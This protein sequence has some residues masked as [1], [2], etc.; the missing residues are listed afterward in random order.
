MVL[1]ALKEK[2]KVKKAKSLFGSLSKYRKKVSDKEVLGETIDMVAENAAK[3][4]L[5]Y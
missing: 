2:F 3:E 5:P 4:G 1:E